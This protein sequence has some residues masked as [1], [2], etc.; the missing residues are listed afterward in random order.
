M[1]FFRDFFK[2]VHIHYIT[3]R[4]LPPFSHK[5]NHLEKASL[6]VKRIDALSL[7]VEF[8]EAEKKF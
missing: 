8:P 3:I 2:S 7:S 5:Q 1:P 6:F 4:T